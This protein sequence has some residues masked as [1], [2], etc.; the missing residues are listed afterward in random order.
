MIGVWHFR[1]LALSQ[2]V[3]FFLLAFPGARETIF[4]AGDEHTTIIHKHYHSHFAGGGDETG[5]PGP[6]GPPNPPGPP[7]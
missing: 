7:G 3:V 6:P 4:N 5:P 2:L 1:V